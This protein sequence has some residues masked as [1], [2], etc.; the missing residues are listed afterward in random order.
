MSDKSTNMAARLM[1]LQALEAEA[2]KKEKGYYTNDAGD[3]AC[4]KCHSD[5]LQ[6]V[7]IFSIHDGPFPLSGSGKTEQQVF[8]YC[9]TCEEKPEIQGMPI[10]P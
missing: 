3:I 10:T 7:V 9:P 1:T 4:K 2:K 5:I 6:T 8:P